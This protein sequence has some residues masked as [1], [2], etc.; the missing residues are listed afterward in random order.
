MDADSSMSWIA[1]GAGTGKRSSPERI[2]QVVLLDRETNLEPL[3]GIPAEDLP[4]IFDEFRQVDGA[5]GSRQ[6]GTGLGLAIV[7]KSME[8]LGGSI[9]VESQVGKGTTF[10]MRLVDCPSEDGAANA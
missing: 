6:E 9:A 4:H 1:W 7:K 5:D 3:L 10:I 2:G 8:L